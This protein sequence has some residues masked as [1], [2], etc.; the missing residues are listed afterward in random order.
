MRPPVGTVTPTTPPPAVDREHPFTMTVSRRI[1]FAAHGALEFPL[2]LALMASPF[3]VGADAAGTAIALVLG[4]LVAGV[5][6]TSVGGPRGAAI[7]L[8]THE[9]YDQALALGGAGGAV[10]L[11]VA[12]QGPV[13]LAVLGCSLALLA[14]SFATRYSG[15]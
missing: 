13:A 7:P 11:A 1:P 4:A 3:L 9:S 14:L 12:G 2:G 6:L 10:A 5:A 15:R 8:S